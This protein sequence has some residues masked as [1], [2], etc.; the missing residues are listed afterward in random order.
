MN[1]NA[2]L[3]ALKVIEEVMKLLNIIEVHTYVC[4]YIVIIHKICIASLLCNNYAG[5]LEYLSL[6]LVDWQLVY[7]VSTGS[8]PRSMHHL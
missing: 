8:M 7:V 4:T 6:S 1:I 2:M 5:I 3:S